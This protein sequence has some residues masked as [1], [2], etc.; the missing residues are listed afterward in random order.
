MGDLY[1]KTATEEEM[2]NAIMAAGVTSSDGIAV[3]GFTVEHIGPFTK[4]IG[5]T[6]TGEPIEQFYP[7]WHTNIRGSFNEAQIDMLTPICVEPV[8]PYRIFA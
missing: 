8:D 7:E 4:I 1:L 5:Y 3:I 2:V 6:D